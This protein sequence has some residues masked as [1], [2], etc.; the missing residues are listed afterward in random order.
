MRP[1]QSF[2]REQVQKVKQDWRR[3]SEARDTEL[4]FDDQT[5]N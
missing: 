2:N 4:G 5:Q 1:T 3:R